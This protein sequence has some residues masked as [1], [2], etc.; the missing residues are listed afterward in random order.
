MRDSVEDDEEIE[1]VEDFDENNVDIQEGEGE[2]EAHVVSIK[3]GLRFLLPGR[4]A[5]EE[6][7]ENGDNDNLI[8]FTF[9]RYKIKPNLSL[10]FEFIIELEKSSSFSSSELIC[11]SIFSH[12]L[13]NLFN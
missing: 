7:G 2:E 5:E 1:E 13:T 4:D 9:G 10:Y 11:F 12:C 3:L 6:E 8:M